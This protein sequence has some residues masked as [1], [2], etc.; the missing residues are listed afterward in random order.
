M[1]SWRPK[2][3]V[4]GSYIDQAW[5]NAYVGWAIYR[6]EVMQSCIRRLRSCMYACT[7]TTVR[8]TVRMVSNI[9]RRSC[10]AVSDVCEAGVRMNHT[11]VR[12]MYTYE[13]TQTHTDTHRDTPR[14]W[15]PQHTD[16]HRQTPTHTETHHGLA[17]SIHKLGRPLSHND[18][19][20]Q[21]EYLEHL[22][23]GSLQGIGINDLLQTWVLR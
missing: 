14:P 8:V 21:R 11:F 7:H 5:D 20:Q 12:Q 10:R 1:R 17:D 16:T 13:H 3:Y 23:Q 9:D 15:K 19:T 2:S 4:C 18:E 6:P 22:P